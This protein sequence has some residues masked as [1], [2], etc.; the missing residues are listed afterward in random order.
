MPYLGILGHNFEKRMSH[1]EIR[2]LEF[3]LLQ[4][5]VQKQKI[6]KFGTKNALFGYFWA[7][8]LK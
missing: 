8:S 5:L 1:F 3:I 6:L 4:T 7:K 2:A